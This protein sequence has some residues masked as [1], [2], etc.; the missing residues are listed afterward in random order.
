MDRNKEA[1]RAELLREKEALQENIQ[2]A[3]RRLEMVE[4]GLRVLDDDLFSTRP[5]V[6]PLVFTPNGSIRNLP[7]RIG[8]LL[9][10]Q[11][12]AMTISDMADLWFSFSMKITLNE[13]RRRISVQASAMYKN[14]PSGQT[15]PIV[16]APIPRSI[17]REIYWSRPT[18]IADGVLLDAYAPHSDNTSD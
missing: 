11:G 7:D 15:P 12:R 8:E 13:L 5:T 1:K 16:P 4:F 18:W 10:S 2:S 9:D 3:Q 17:N 14:T 6:P